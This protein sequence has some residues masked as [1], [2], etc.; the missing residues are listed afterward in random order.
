LLATSTERV[1][2]E[3]D[4]ELVGTL[5]GVFDILPGALLIKVSDE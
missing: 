3:M 1:F 4:G 2:I 5:P